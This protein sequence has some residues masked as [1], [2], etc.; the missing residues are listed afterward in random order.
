[1]PKSTTISGPLIAVVRRDGIDKT[2]GAD[3]LRP[4]DER[5]ARRIVTPGSPTTSGSLRQY[6]RHS[7]RKLKFASGTT[8]AMIV[9]V[10]LPPR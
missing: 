6:S 9:A 3:L 8:L 1:M 7:R 4:V 5:R 10:D 2:V